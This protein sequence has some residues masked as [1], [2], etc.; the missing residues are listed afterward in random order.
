MR[1]RDG[2]LRKLFKSN[3]PMV[4]W[5]PVELG[6][7]GSG[8]PDTNFCYN[9]IEGWIE[10]K[11]TEKNRIGLRPEQIGWIIDRIR[12][13]GR[14]KVAIRVTHYGEESLMMFDGAVAEDLQMGTITD[15]LHHVIGNWGGPPR[16]WCWQEIL[17]ALVK[18]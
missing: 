13:G 18:R 8:V 6:A 1:E 15:N 2:G 12:H 9:G 4:H 14:V 17:D 3:L 16:S 7:I 5:Q 11:Q 10:F